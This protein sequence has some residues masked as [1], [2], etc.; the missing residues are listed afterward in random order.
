MSDRQTVTQHLV[1]D[2]RPY[3]VRLIHNPIIDDVV[4]TEAQLF[5]NELVNGP[6]EERRVAREIRDFFIRLGVER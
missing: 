6:G 1:V 3:R 5:A 4:V 2:G